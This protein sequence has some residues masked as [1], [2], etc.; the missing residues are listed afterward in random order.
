MNEKELLKKYF[1]FL[2]ELDTHDLAWEDELKLRE[3]LKEGR[4]LLYPQV[5]IVKVHGDK[6]E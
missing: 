2:S 5:P 4:E 1:Q 3:L 6:A